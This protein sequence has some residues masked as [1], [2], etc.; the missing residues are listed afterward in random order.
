[1][2]PAYVYQA[3]YFPIGERSMSE[4]I[5]HHRRRFLGTAA[6]TMAAAQF[7]MIGC[8]KAQSTAAV[9]LPT[10]GVFP[11]LGSANAW[12]NSQP[13]AA[14]GLRGKVVL[15]DFWTYTCI[16]WLRTLPYVR[17]WAEKYKTQ[18][19]VV[20]GVHTPEFAFE[21][22]LD[23]VRR[24]AKDMGVDYP[25]A[26]DS[27]YAIWRAFKNEYWPALYFID[28]KGQIRHHHF[29][30][31]EYERSE[32]IVQQLLSEAGIGGIGH[33]LVSVDARGAEAAADWGSLKSPENYVGYARTENFA[34]PG[35]A[36][37]EKRHVYAAPA[38]LAL[39]HWALSGDWTVEKQL[40]VLNKANGRIAYR[41][42]ARDLHLVMGPAA[43]GA[44]VR[45]RVL[46]DGRP[47]GAAHGIDVDGQG[48]GTVAEQ[49][50]YQL[51]RQPKPI[52]DRQFEIEFL[53]SGVE[54]F[55]FT[56]G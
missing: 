49:R 25:I 8:A 41:F 56:F 3:G 15:I 36:V 17:A 39:N 1:M 34:S 47:P 6:M 32:M 12:L 27:D 30:E 20:I 23:N 21:K 50:L 13:L 38:Q 45:F 29:G 16:N 51:I 11:S 18:G 35:G 55:A 4:E 33:G 9:Q 24:A 44:S 10:E 52:A 53:D 5:N 28:A 43:R 19:L 48:N 26:I 2:W 14:A 46:I 40:T 42:H 54:V 22:N 37:S 7:G 31:G